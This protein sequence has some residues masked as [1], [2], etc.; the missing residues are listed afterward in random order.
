MTNHLIL[1][2]ARIEKSLDL[3][4]IS[5]ILKIKARF[6]KQI[7][8]NKEF[9][10][11]DQNLLLYYKK[12]YARFLDVNVQLTLDNNIEHVINR[13]ITPSFSIYFTILSTIVLCLLLL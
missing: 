2:Q 13:A 1:K 10:I 11:N 9:E 6:L 7:E 3:E 12:A 4:Q 5:Q 8:D